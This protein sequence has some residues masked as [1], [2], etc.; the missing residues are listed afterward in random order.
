MLTYLC[1]IIRCSPVSFL[2]AFFYEA[3]VLSSMP[4]LC[5]CLVVACSR[6]IPRTFTTSLVTWDTKA[7][8]FS[9]MTAVGKY[10]SLVVVLVMTLAP[11]LAS[12]FV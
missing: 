12:S 10:A 9:E 2:S 6:V 8:P 1:H 11:I 5:I 4:M 7:D 3:C